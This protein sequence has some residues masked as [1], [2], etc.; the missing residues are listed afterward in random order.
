MAQQQLLW[1]L[2]RAAR[3]ATALLGLAALGTGC[4]SSYA[5]KPALEYA[6]VEYS[7][8]QGNTW[9]ESRLALPQT[10][11]KYALP[12]TPEITYVEVNPGAAPTVV[13]IHGLGSY[14][15]FWRYQV[16][17]VASAG[18]HVIALDML[19]YGKSDKPATFPYTMEAM[20][21]VVHELVRAK[22]L[23]R[24]ILMGHSMGGQTA[25]SYS[26]EFPGDLSGLILVS[27]AGFEAFSPKEKQWFKNVFSSK[28]ILAADEEAIWGSI[29]YGN[30]YRWTSDFEWLIEERVRAV[31]NSQFKA[32]AYANVKSV[33]GLLDNEFVRANLH[34]ITVPTLIVHGDRD[35]L[36]P[37][38]YL[39]GGNTADVM[40][41]GHANI[42]GSRLVT[43][44]GC[45]H[46]LQLDCHQEFN[47]V[48]LGFLDKHFPAGKHKA[49]QP[50][51]QPPG[52]RSAP[53]SRPAAQPPEVAPS[54]AEEPLEPASPEEPDEELPVEPSGGAE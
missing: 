12:I 8:P 18:Y 54:E 32:Y 27:P 24:P 30:F 13:M 26:I 53:A 31:K 2:S 5:N 21:E 11:K 41:Y 17:E 15:K 6:N 37:N 20:A 10:A 23:E 29:R 33:H 38:P 39:H 42:A 1:N 52:E 16:D 49:A 19:G 40:E 25:M 47:R 48:A 36:I 7:S 46:S 3:R 35:R 4:V 51:P 50:E 22:G 45:G 43:L 28:L 9:P 44:S 34:Q 14:L